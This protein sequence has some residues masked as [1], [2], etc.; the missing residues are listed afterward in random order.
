M[1]LIAMDYFFAIDFDGT[2]AKFDVTDA[3]L[4]RFASPEWLVVEKLWENGQIGSKECLRKQMTLIDTPLAEVLKF[5]ENIQID[6]SFV[7]FIQNMQRQKVSLAIISDGFRVFIEAILAKNGIVGLEIFANE[8][9]ETEGHLITEYP[10]SAVNCTSGT[11]KCRTAQQAAAGLPV[12]LIGD[13]R[14]DFCL[15]GAAD[16]VYAKAKLVD[17]C[18]Q[19]AITHCTYNDFNDILED[20]HKQ[21]LEKS[22]IA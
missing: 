1:G 21:N 22:V 2:I 10:Y 9:H 15:A 19:E 4:E 8:L 17:Y 16:F 13:G 14:S 5:V 20:L 6:S 3:V 18:Q 11:C 12:Y 7:S